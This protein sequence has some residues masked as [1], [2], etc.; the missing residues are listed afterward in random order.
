MYQLVDDIKAGRARGHNYANDGRSQVVN[1]RKVK[2]QIL[3]KKGSNGPI[4]YKSYD[5]NPKPAGS[6]DKSRILVG[7]DGSVWHTNQHYKQGSI[8]KIN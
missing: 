8:K 3:P 7:S 4:T 6:R 2:S 1:G 5:L